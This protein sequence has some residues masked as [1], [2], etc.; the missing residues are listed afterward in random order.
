MALTKVSTGLLSTE[1]SSVDLSIDA[2]TLYIDST[3][4][5]VGISNTS[6]TTQLDVTG[7]LK[8]SGTS[9]VGALTFTSLTNTTN[10]ITE[11]ANNKYFTDAR[12]AAIIPAGSLA[13]TIGNVK[14]QYRPD[15]NYDDAAGSAVAGSFYFDAL[16]SRLKVHTG[17]EFI[18]AIPFT[19]GGGGGST[20]D[21]NATF[22]NYQYTVTGSPTNTISGADTQ[23]LPS[24]DYI[25]GKSY[26]ISSPGTTDFTTFGS[27]DN[28]SGTQ[29][30]ATGSGLVTAGDFVIGDEYTI[31]YEGDSG[32][33]TN[34]VLVGAT[35]SNPG[36]TFTATNNG[37]GTGTATQGSGT[38][39]AVLGYST[40][41]AS[42]VVVYVNGI[43]QRESSVDGY[44]A[45]SGTSVGF[46]Y[47]LP[48]DSI[49][50]IQVY[51][52]LT[53][54]AYYTKLETYTQAE[55]NT[56]ISTALS[57]YDDQTASDTR[58]V[59][60]TGDTMTGNLSFGDNGRAIFGAG[61][62]LEILSNGTDGLIRNGNATGEIRM[63]SD[64]RI[65]FADRG[66]N[67]VFAVFNDDDDVKLYH[68][69]NQKLATTSTGIDVTGSVTADGLTV[70][71]ANNS[72]NTNTPTIVM[73]DLDVTVSAGQFTGAVEFE[74]SDTNNPGVNSYIRSVMTGTG[75]GGSLTFGTGFAGSLADRVLIGGTGDIS[76]YEETGTSRKLYWDA[77]TERLGLGT[78]SPSAPLDVRAE[79][80]GGET[81]ILVY[82]TDNSNTTT[83]SARIKLGPDSRGEALAGM[84]AYKSTA[85]YTLNTDRDAGLKLY[86][87]NNNAEVDVMTMTNVGTV[88]I[89]QD[90][91]SSQLHINAS[92]SSSIKFERSAN[93]VGVELATTTSG[94]WGLY[95]Y[96]STSY[97]VYMKAG[98]VSIGDV[99]PTATL[100]LTKTSDTAE[101]AIRIENNSAR[102][103]VGVEGAAGNRFSGSAV[104]NGFIGT[105]TAH[106][107]EFGTNNA[108][109]MRIDIAGNVGIGVVPST[110]WSSSYDALQI[111]LG[112]SVYAHDGAGSNMQI[113]ANVVY[114]GIS[115]N[116]YD[117]YLTSSTAS[118]YVQDSGLHIWSI[119]ASG[120]AG[121]NIA[122]SEAMRIDSLGNLLVGTTTADG[123]Y[124]ESDG[125][126]ATVFM[127]ASIGG[128]ANGSAFVSRRA[129]PLQ[130]NRQANDGDIAVFRKDGSPVGSI[131]IEA[132][133]FYID[134][135]ASHAGLSFGGN[136]IAPRDN[137]VRVDNTV[138][139]GSDVH[140]FKDLYLSGG[141]VFGATGGAVTS[142]TMDDYEEGTWTPAFDSV[143]GLTN[144]TGLSD[145][146]ARYTRVGNTVQAHFT[147]KLTN[148]GS[149]TITA[150]DY[151]IITNASL[152]FAPHTYV[153]SGSIDQF[154]GDHVWYQSI[155]TNNIASG[156]VL[157]GTGGTY[158]H[159]GV[160]N[161]TPDTGTSAYG[162]VRLQYDIS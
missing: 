31:V 49:V 156:S 45:T 50:D 116:F 79:N 39:H 61:S 80:I 55:T 142:K 117:K 15:G 59:N 86:T 109:R 16:N 85:D 35:D 4:N 94:G 33:E 32:T 22:V 153:T 97:D 93:I 104:G 125:G 143:S 152:P 120:T 157:W 102:L 62:D 10:D 75:G 132:G 70:N 136:S 76:F 56:Q 8:V 135:E 115:P 42:D 145:I 19:A 26:E 139:L 138:D 124:D 51:E 111:G 90:V 148:S 43:K 113:A 144:V 7:N 72:G 29:F 23:E 27:A 66:F 74:T 83:Q 82:N 162:L 131:G 112:G 57:V 159:F 119:A 105:T 6:P 87:M 3:Q 89:G 9:Q 40:T 46:T 68:D 98:Q 48:V 88:G 47:N 147:Y 118:K 37:S 127:G 52:L 12:V 2:G 110:V 149:E 24:G 17:S 150:G 161:G 107:L 5:F 96:A 1:L 38:A 77:S 60:V 18:D 100:D 95:D 13:G 53:N 106:G 137:G 141:V 81:S 11:G 123:G 65:I 41:S 30:V 21:A 69:G 20:A 108:V 44:Q 92:G 151:F 54:D 25:I 36:T 154:I 155:G 58:Y 160:I 99:S 28:V 129:A 134:G 64:D 126:A 103:Y 158:L 34:F 122:W 121:N 14:M 84:Q 101:R 71:S 133:G 63:E 130:L 73:K 91:P 146:D 78:T 67:E 114:E 128:A 140:R